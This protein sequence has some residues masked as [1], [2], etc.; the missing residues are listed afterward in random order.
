M[1]YQIWLKQSTV[2]NPAVCHDKVVNQHLLLAQAY[3]MMMNHLTSVA[4]FPVGGGGIHPD[5]PKYY[6]WQCRL[7]IVCYGPIHSYNYKHKKA[8]LLNESSG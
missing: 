7:C 2:T 3:P 1:H 4:K 8:S 5:P 6:M